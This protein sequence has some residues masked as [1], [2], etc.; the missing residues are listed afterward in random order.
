M[1]IIAALPAYNEEI[2]IG[3]IVL[4][5]RKH[6]EKVI[7]VDDGSSDATSKVAELAG[8]EVV[9][10]ETNMGKGAALR[11]AFQRAIE[12]N[13]DVLVIL[14]ADG[15]HNPDEI[16][17][18]VAP[19]QKGEADVVIGSRFLE[20]KHSV[21]KY[22]RIGQEVLTF[23]TNLIAK[24]KITDSQSGF[25]AFSKKATESLEFKE[26]GISIESQMLHSAS[27]SKLRIKEVP[28]SCEYD[29]IKGSKLNPF[30]HGFSVVNAILRIA[31]E[32]RPLLFFC[33]PGFVLVCI[34]MFFGIRVVSIFKDAGAFAIGTAVVTL[35]F[36]IVG[37]LSIFTGIMLHTI[38]GV[39]RKSYWR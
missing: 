18:L 29:V 25:R 35:L 21:P 8:A 33:V 3:S 36:V 28:I 5:A 23:M 32:R 26:V 22:R 27:N 13:A 6:V 39:L 16:P 14:D 11:D 1:K 30:H 15:Q 17:R 37:V 10:H 20:G 4:R 19:I 38:T 12:L 7:V 24:T 31:G 34:G 9:R 2:A